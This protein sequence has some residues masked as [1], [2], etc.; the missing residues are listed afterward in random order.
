MRDIVN[1]KLAV[2]QAKTE[3]IEQ[4]IEKLDGKMRHDWELET[5]GNSLQEYKELMEFLSNTAGAL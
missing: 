2:I 5:P 1:D 3:Q 4:V